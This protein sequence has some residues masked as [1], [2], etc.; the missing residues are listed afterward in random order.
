MPAA[1]YDKTD[2]PMI[3]QAEATTPDDRSPVRL[4]ARLGRDPAAASADRDGCARLD[5]AFNLLH[6]DESI[7][8]VIP[9]IGLA[10]GIDHSLFYLRH[11]YREERAA[12][13]AGRSTRDHGGD[14]GRAVLVSGLTVM[15][16]M[17]GMFLMGTAC[18][19]A[20]D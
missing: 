13:P 20:S 4:Q 12:P 2:S 8:S 17:S 7:N 1:W 11:A 15:A 5:R 18:S 6:A 19:K 16:A 10:G 9:L 14:V 3:H